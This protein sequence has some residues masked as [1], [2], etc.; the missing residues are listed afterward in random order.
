MSSLVNSLI[1]LK[2]LFQSFSNYS[3]NWRGNISEL[4]F[5][6]QHYLDNKAIQRHYRTRKPIP[7]INIDAKILIEPCFYHQSHPQLGLPFTV[8]GVISPLI[9]SSI[10]GTYQPGEFIFQCP[11]FLPFYSI[12]GF[13][14]QE[15]WFAIPFSSGP[16]SIRPLHHDLSILGGPPWHDLVSL[17]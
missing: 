14:R 13:S 9:S 4:I 3:E 8:S 16:H 10:L 2:N 6:S 12:M 1:H 11:I 17:S 15:Y 7:L 5:W